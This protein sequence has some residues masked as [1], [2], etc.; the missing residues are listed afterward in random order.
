[1]KIATEMILD[2]FPIL[3]EE[4]TANESVLLSNQALEKLSEVEQVFLRLAWFFERPEEENFNLDSLYN[5][6]DNDWL[7]FALEVIYTF[8]HKDTY[9]IQNPTNSI[10]TG[11]DIYM[12][13][14]RF[15]N[16]LNENGLKYDKAKMS[17][18]IKRGII[19][20]ADIT[21]SGTKYWERLTC[22]N[23]LE[24]ELDKNK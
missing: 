9:L 12:N 15:A 3:E 14:T 10:I 21:V 22:E 23:F 2:E 11:K 24:Y 17:T 13:Q 4:I 5:H 7:E 16:F 8:F 18:Y 1:M 6:L 19:P 20:P